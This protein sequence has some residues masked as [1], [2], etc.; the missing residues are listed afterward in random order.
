MNRR[1]HGP[2]LNGNSITT[3]GWQGKQNLLATAMVLLNLLLP[4]AEQKQLFDNCHWAE[5]PT[6]P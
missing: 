1:H 2:P 6:M 3:I 4:T 5:Q